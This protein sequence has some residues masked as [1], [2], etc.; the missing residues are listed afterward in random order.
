MYYA[1]H[2]PPHFH[3]RY[4]D[5]EAQVLISSGEVL[6]GQLP[7]RADALVHEWWKLH[8][9]EL[10]ENWACAERNEPLAGID[11]LP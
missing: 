10:A 1:D 9:E 6:R 7:R 5:D 3:A 11:P 4:G 2:A 8:R